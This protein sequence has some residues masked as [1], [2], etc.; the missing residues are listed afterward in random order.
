MHGDRGSDRGRGVTAQ[1]IEP[2]VWSVRPCD[3]NR[4]LAV[5]VI[6]FVLVVSLGM[7]LVGGGPGWAVIALL[8]LGLSVAPYYARVTYKISPEEASAAGWFGTHRRKWAEIKGYFPDAEG[9]LLSP[10]PKPTRLAYTRGLYLRFAGNRDEVMHR[11]EAY[12]EKAARET[13]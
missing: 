9:V 8:L 4:P 12:L 11:V 6:V 7:Q 10:L 13:S 2:L 3:A 5:V 1:R